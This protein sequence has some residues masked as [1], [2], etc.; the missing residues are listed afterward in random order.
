MGFYKRYNTRRSLYVTKARF[1][2]T[3]AETGQLIK[4]GEE[5]V[6]DPNTRQCYHSNS[7]QAKETR[8]QAWNE[9]NCMADSNW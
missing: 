6:Y 2:S 9:A 5:M 4:T 1:D 3:C 8:Q 7:I